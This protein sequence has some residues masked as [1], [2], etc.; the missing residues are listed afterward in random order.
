MKE[1]KKAMETEFN[2]YDRLIEPESEPVT[3]PV[4]LGNLNKPEHKKMAEKPMEIIPLASEA[5]YSKIPVR[6]FRT[7]ETVLLEVEE[8]LLVPDTYPDMEIILNMD[9]AAEPAEI[10]SE[11][12]SAD[13]KGIIKLETMYRSDENYG[14]NISVLPAEMNYS[15]EINC[16]EKISASV[17]VTKVEYRIINERKY[18]ARVFL[19]VNVKCESEKDYLIFEGIEGETL[20][21]HNEH[22]SL[23]DMISRKTTESDFS[24]ELF[25]NDEKIRPVKI[26]KSS[27][28]VAENHRQLTKEK[29]IL[30]QTLWVRVMYLA[31]IAS[32]GN[33]SN[34]AMFF[35]GKI[36]HTQFI[37]LSRSEGEVEACTATSTVK[38]LKVQINRESSGFEVSGE[39]ATEMTCYGL[40]ERDLVTDFYHDKEEM[41][42]DRKSE[43][44]C[45]DVSTVSAEQTIRESISLQQESGDELRIIYLDAQPVDIS[46]DI[47]GGA[48]VVRGRLHME[49][50]VMNEGDYTML[51]KK[52]C[53]F[54]CVKELSQDT[55]SCI[56]PERIFVREMKG[57]ISGKE[58]N[59]TAQVQ[60]NL[61]I[62]NEAEFL[63]IKNPC[64]IRSGQPAKCY[65]I[66]IHTVMDG[67]TVWDIGK[68]YKVSEEHIT[69]YNKEENIKPGKKIIIVK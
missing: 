20:Y 2:P 64:I 16:E 1:N 54:T 49:A 60:A 47:E 28:T 66:T 31:E 67:E 14:S 32:K 68:K 63:H 5:S 55:G 15:K 22:I 8:D 26:L 27:I 59:L 40:V 35:Q 62:Y 44:V 25:I 29:L 7:V 23:L 46:V 13:I 4:I 6:E 58:L 39:I 45:V 38:N 18:R 61:N 30:N 51:A 53:D 19:A 69:H 42:C 41:T 57:D 65:P 52:I 43:M 17:H 37:N 50:V 9:A 56:E 24:E 34:Q 33:L 10:Y 3:S 21:L 12:G 48:A 11:N 36:D